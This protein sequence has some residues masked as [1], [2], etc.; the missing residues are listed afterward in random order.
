MST[1]ENDWIS[2]DDA[3]VLA[4]CSADSIKRDVKN[5]ALETRQG[6]ANRVMVRLSDLVGIGRIK[7]H[8]L[9]SSGTGAEAAELR[10][11]QERILS[12]HAEV[13]EATGRLGERDTVIEVLRQQLAE[14]DRQLKALT[15]LF[16]NTVATF[17]AG[18]AA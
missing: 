10:R 13:G 12:L 8:E 18:R 17:R 9:P 1:I 16:D 15:A 3:A 4:G 5:H 7:Q 2:R 6:P 11:A 14:K